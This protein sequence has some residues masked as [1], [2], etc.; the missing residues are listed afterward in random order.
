VRKI[1]E[2]E[3]IWTSEGGRAPVLEL[4]R[5]L[6][7]AGYDPGRPLEVYRGD[8]LCLRVRSIGEGAKLFIDESKDAR[9]TLSSPFAGAGKGKGE[10]PG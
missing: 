9:F 6:V 7:R 3:G 8:V 2:A 5:K 10:A 4:C 1:L